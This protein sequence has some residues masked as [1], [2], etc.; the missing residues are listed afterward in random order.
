MPKESRGLGAW[1]E[2]RF[3]QTWL[4]LRG[5][6]QSKGS[7]LQE[8][9]DVRN[10]ELRQ[11]IL[12]KSKSRME[13]FIFG[14]AGR[15]ES[16]WHPARWGSEDSMVLG[17]KKALGWNPSERACMLRPR[18]WA[19]VTI[20]GPFCFYCLS[21]FPVQFCYRKFITFTMH[22]IH[23]QVKASKGFSL[24]FHLHIVFQL[25]PSAALKKTMWGIILNIRCNFIKTRRPPGLAPAWEVRLT[26]LACVLWL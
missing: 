8:L 1:E 21:S 5:W 23:K 11:K 2:T 20:V 25:S 9:M 26:L 19:T 22:C 14:Y 7:D 12:G 16:V 24:P 3:R 18:H 13:M 17:L 4:L 6:D 15:D 10:K